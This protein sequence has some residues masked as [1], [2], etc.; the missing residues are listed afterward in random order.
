MTQSQ[1]AKE[2]YN[3]YYFQM[4]NRYPV[5]FINGKGCKLYDDNGNEYLDAL[6]G[7]A[8]NSLGH[9]HPSLVKAIQEQ[10]AT[11]MHISNFYYNLPQSQ[12][13]EKLNKVSTI[14]RVFFCNSGVEANEGAIKLA[15]KYAHEH[16]K[17]GNIYSFTG[18]F[19][20]RSLATVAMGKK[21]YQEGFEPMPGGF[22]MLP[23][24]D[25]SA[26]D[27]IS[28]ND[29][30]VFIEF[31]QGEGGVNPANHDFV[32]KLGNICQRNN[33]LLIA[34]EIQTG[35]G[36]TGS[37]FGFQHYQVKPD[38]ITLAKGLAGGFPIGAVMA[39]ENISKSFKPGNHSTTFGGNPLA[40]AAAFA[41]LN[42]I[43][44]EQLIDNAINM[45]DY[46]ITQLKESFGNNPA[47]KEIR[48]VGL[49]IGLELNFSCGE[50]VKNL[51]KNK[52]LVSCTAGNV[53]RF[54]PPL[55][56]SKTEIDRIIEIVGKTL[57]EMSVNVNY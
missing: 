9:C 27:K 44:N 6:A 33:V 34:D 35:I 25:L 26:L 15:R 32:E 43:E 42:T 40:C 57:E 21:M 31:I 36:R 52:L 5:T 48:G 55:I 3:D 45:G 49:L 2:L 1:D 7:I 56:I 46:F 8:V 4:H 30:A 50:L 47:V 10:A 28:E 18:C 11:L 53:V 51:L 37:W 19:H 14:D 39:K 20:G 23:F 24:N 12:L 17:T 54:A 16:G 29:I 38:I 22:E 13:A 41:T